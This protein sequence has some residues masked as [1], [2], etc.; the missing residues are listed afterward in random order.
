M[1][2]NTFYVGIGGFIGSIARYWLGIAIHAGFNQPWFPYATL[3]VNAL[4]C[5]A[6]GWVLALIMVYEWGSPELRLFLFVGLF[7]GFTTFSALS[8]QTFELYV[9]GYI[10]ASV[11]NVLA[12]VGISLVMVWLGYRLGQ[13][14]YA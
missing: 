9:H 3:M 11:F 12:Q 8:V 6:A 14:N 4:G 7:G 5:F 13:I 1:L 2:L 10:V